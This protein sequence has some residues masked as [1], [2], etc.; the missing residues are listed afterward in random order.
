MVKGVETRENV[1][2]DTRARLKVGAISASMGP[3]GQRP[4]TVPPVCL[5]LIFRVYCG[6]TPGF[7]NRIAVKEFDR[8]SW[9]YCVI[10][11]P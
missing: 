11:R 4:P 7:K 1:V 10:G 6:R 3:N 2:C 9:C 5:Y 8:Y